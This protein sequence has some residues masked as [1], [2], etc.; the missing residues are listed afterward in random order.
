[1]RQKN[2]PIERIDDDIIRIGKEMLLV[3]HAMNGAG[4]AAPQVGI[5]KRLMVMSKENMDSVEDVIAIN[6]VITLRSKNMWC[7]EEGCLSFPDLWIDVDRNVWIEVEYLNLDGER[8]SKRLE[9]FPAILFQHEYD[10]IDQVSWSIVAFL[11]G[12]FVTLVCLFAQVLFIDRMVPFC[13]ESAIVREKL[14]KMIDDFGPGGA[15]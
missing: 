12:C 3:M 7:S 14:T 6:P 11:S 4:L 10:H 5:N 8:V 2:E 15:A 9:G 1:M 13:R